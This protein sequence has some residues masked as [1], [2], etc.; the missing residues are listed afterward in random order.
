MQISPLAPSPQPRPTDETDGALMERVRQ[1]DEEA[2]NVII[3]RH[4]APLVSYATGVVR[5]RDVAEDIVQ[6]TFVRLWSHRKGWR[7]GGSVRAYLYRTAHNLVLG[8]V[9]HLKV[10]QRTEPEVQQAFEPSSNSPL[11]AAAEEELRTALRSAVDALPPRRREALL[12]VRFHGL[13]LDEAAERMHLSRQ[14]VANHITLALDD[15]EVSLRD[16]WN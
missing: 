16:F 15:L 8:Q 12:L 4:W 7:S 11:E 1:D 3:Q 14:T 5:A 13:S 2:L 6:E 10:Q 9:R